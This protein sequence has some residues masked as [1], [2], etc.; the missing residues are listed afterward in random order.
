MTF[1]NAFERKILY[2]GLQKI[3]IRISFHDITDM[4]VLARHT[5]EISH[6]SKVPC[7]TVLLVSKM[8]TPSCAFIV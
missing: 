7:F 5:C 3:T 2:D 4:T 8:W 1:V 6:I